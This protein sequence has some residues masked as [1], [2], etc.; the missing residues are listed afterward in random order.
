[1]EIEKPGPERK[2]AWDTEKGAV[3]M[4]CIVQRSWLEVAGN[5]EQL[6]KVLADAS[7]QQS[8][9]LFILLLF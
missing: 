8:R 4:L 1:M 2:H 6:Q 3:G 5:S 9:G 7:G